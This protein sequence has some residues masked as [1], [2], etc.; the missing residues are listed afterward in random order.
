MARAYEVNFDGIVG[1]THNYSGLAFGNVA[2][3]D[4]KN[5]VSNPKEAALQGLNK[6][7]ALYKMGLKQA[8]LPPLPRPYL[9]VLEDIGFSGP[10]PVILRNCTHDDINILYAV[11]SSASMWTANAATVT[12]SVDSD[13]SRLQ[14]TIA[15]LSSK[16]HRSIEAPS[17]YIVFKR[18][19]NDETFFRVYPALPQGS[20]FTDEGAANHTRLCNEYG[21]KGVNFFVYGRS[22]FTVLPNVPKKYPARQSV[23][24]SHAVVRLNAVDRKHIVYAQQNPEAVDAGVFHNDVIAVGNQ[25]VFLYHE[26]AYVDTQKV[27]DELKRKVDELGFY[28]HFIQVNKD[29]LS[30]QDA[31]QTYFFNSQLVTLP[32]KTMVLIAPS[33]CENNPKV[34]VYL[35]QLLKSDTPIK[36]VKYFNLR[37]SMRNGGGP[38]CLR[39]RVVMTDQELNAMH[40]KVLLDDELYKTLC[41]WVEKHYRDKLTPADLSD[42][43]LH[44]EVTEALNELTGILDLGDVFQYQQKPF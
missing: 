25:N 34:K 15:N 4:N 29:Q 19:F 8:V 24:A 17:M 31:V 37:E 18:I 44:D 43:L 28:V 42:P 6:M 40:K 32:D 7:Y 27:I 23:E 33:E 10:S 12:S 30:L 20:F 5:A 39:L 3:V 38:A 14:F 21:D 2:S 35:D 16:F 11:S 1:Q 41:G 22:S 26:E 13:D 36:S 9:Q